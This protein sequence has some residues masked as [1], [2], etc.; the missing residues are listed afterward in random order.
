MVILM[1]KPIV[2]I[3][4]ANS[5][6]GKAAAEKFASEQCKVIMA[7][8]NPQKAE[9]ARQEIADKFFFADL[10]VMQLD[11]SSLESIEHFYTE[12]SNRFDRLD[13]LIHNAAYFSHGE[14]QYQLSS[15]GIEL[16]FA[17]NTIGPFYLT[18]LLKKHLSGS[19]GPRILN[20]CTTNIKHFFD[21]KREIEFDNLRGEYKDSRPYS[22]YKQYGDSK[23]ALL[24]LT[25]I[26][27]DQFNKDGIKVNAVMINNIRQE[28]QSLMKFKSWYRIVAIF[29]NLI[30]R[31]PGMM[32]DVYYQICT[33][34][35]FKHVTGK[36]INHRLEIVEKSK[37]TDD[38][39]A[40]Q[41]AREIQKGNT[42]SVYAEDKDVHE[43][44]LDLCSKL[45]EGKVA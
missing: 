42:Y 8:R 22:V 33:S 5:G 16:T 36:L 21:P 13:I 19:A 17:T 3:T 28:W 30:A 2:I 34:E 25:F 18:N 32:A 23:M 41:V 31:S 11:I 37:L 45:T 39:N 15:D 7:C 27:A 38:H 9:I 10:L 1:D 20:A 40:L 44:V 26:W 14:K 4:G 29:Q 24:M 6:I 43:K 12:F 35:D